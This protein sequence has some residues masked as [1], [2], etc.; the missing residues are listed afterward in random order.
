[1]IRATTRA[2]LIVSAGLFLALGTPSHAAP[3]D[4]AATENA[5]SA[6]AEKLAEPA[7]H[8]RHKHHS[9]HHSAKSNKA[10]DRVEKSERKV[11]SAGPDT[12]R[13]ATSPLP[14]TVANAN[15]SADQPEATSASPA[16]ASAPEEANQRPVVEAPAAPAAETQ[17][18]AADQ[19]NEIDRAIDQD[20]PSAPAALA[21][22]EP[23]AAPTTAVASPDGASWGQA[24]IVGKIFIAFG[25]LLTF[26]SAARMFIA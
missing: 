26:A 19:L 21:A 3:A 14:D 18:V 16:A 1:M 11:I 23:A 10:A 9:E 5:T 4:D 8:S 6:A 22:A 7:R 25:A 13:V 20:P 12:N 15:A 17:T 24:S 2:A